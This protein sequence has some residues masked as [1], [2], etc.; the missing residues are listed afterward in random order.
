MA[1]LAE[2]LT[3]NEL[4]RRHNWFACSL[5]AANISGKGWGAGVG[6]L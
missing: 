6:D 5:G 3:E 1:D 4:S 2:V